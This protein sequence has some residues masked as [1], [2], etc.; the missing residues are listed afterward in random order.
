[1]D[2]RPNPEALLSLSPAVVDGL[3]EAMATDDFSEAIIGRAEAVA[4]GQLDPIRLPLVHHWL[5]A[6]E[7]P[8]A[9][10]ARLFSYRDRVDEAEALRVLGDT[11]LAA[12]VDAGALNRTDAGIVSRLRLMP[13][14]GL[15]VASDEAAARFDPVMGPGATTLQLWRAVAV[16]E[17]ASVL[18]VGCGAGSLALAAAGAGAGTVVGTDIDPRAA[19]FG[20]FN[21]RLNG[22]SD[23]TFVVGDRLEP[24]EGQRFDLVVAQPPFVPRPPS[25]TATTYLHGGDRGDELAWSIIEALPEALA[26]GGRAVVLFDAAPAG[27]EHPL[28]VLRSRIGRT[29]LQATA[30]V[31][32]G[33]SADAQAV[34]Y[35]STAHGELDGAYAEAAAAY[36]AHLSNLGIETMRHV[37]LEIRRV[38]EGQPSFV[39]GVDTPRSRVYSAEE[40]EALR[41][42]I[43]L[44]SSPE[45]SK[46]RVQ[47]SPHAWLGQEQH[48]CGAEAP[49]HRLRFEGGRA[50]DQELSEAA[51]ALV[52]MFADEVEVAEVVR[53]Y[54]ELCEAAPSEVEGAVLQFV[55][56]S[57]VN[58]RLVPKG[59]TREAAGV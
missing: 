42:G 35:A 16:D 45:V 48:L 15:I 13:F 39:A 8:A 56:E 40:L 33:L 21:A 47:A 3:R 38:G 53:R 52:A 14:A 57:L 27:G 12:L 10:W 43:E 37:L 29:G 46:L 19:D 17:G 31:A 20:R 4:P 5:R 32:P 28:A 30:V 55:R 58:G 25:V 6:S 51:A 44:A 1:M 11:G 26:E 54:A 36:R 22:L 41:R 9:I 49:R 50:T 18:D 24:V 34:G 59:N 23:A 2:P 7:E